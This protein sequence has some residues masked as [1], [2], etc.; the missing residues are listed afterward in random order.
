MPTPTTC[1]S[2]PNSTRQ[3]CVRTAKPFYIRQMAFTE[4]RYFSYVQLDIKYQKYI[5]HVFEG[6][7]W[8]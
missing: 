4:A 8:R 1:R 2:E 3:P 5:T 7:L 6:P